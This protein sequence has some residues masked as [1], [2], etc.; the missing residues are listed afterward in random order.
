MIDIK[1]KS[2]CVNII[3]KNWS[4]MRTH[5]NFMTFIV[6]VRQSE[7]YLIIIHNNYALGR[8]YVVQRII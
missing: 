7:P 8:W 5:L 6:I 3:Y 2:M 1:K 4:D